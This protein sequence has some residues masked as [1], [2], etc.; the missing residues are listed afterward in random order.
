[1]TCELLDCDGDGVGDG[2]DNCIGVPN[3]GQI[4]S[5][6]DG[7]GDACETARDN[8]S[9]L[10]T[11]TAAFVGADLRG[12]GIQSS[13]VAVDFTDA[14]LSCSYMNG[15][16]FVGGGT[17]VRTNMSRVYISGSN[18][19][20]NNRFEETNVTDM[21]CGGSSIRGCALGLVGSQS[22]CSQ[23]ET[24]EECTDCGN[25]VLDP[26]EECDLGTQNSNT[27][28]TSSCSMTCE[29]MDCDGDTVADGEDN[30]LGVPNADQADTNSDGVGDACET[31]RANCNDLNTGT[32]TF[33]DADL[34]GCRIGSSSVA[35]DFTDADL[36]CS[37]MNGQNFLGDGTFLR[38]NMSG[39]YV[40]GSNFTGNNRFEE[41]NVTDMVCVGSNVQ[42][43]TLDVVGS[44]ACARLDQL[45]V[46]Q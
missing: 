32:A 38:T 6:S 40:S 2:D 20:G 19:T 8:C 11:G 35:V 28:P 16:R 42:G 46:C 12:C 39:V 31:A 5:D 18:V 25:R 29:L 22:M 21:F 30:C 37:Y 17:F 9:D 34:R 3:A 23:L 14:D 15:Q 4:D 33:V 27:Y 1:M 26:S 45:A 10:N 13:S 24:L 36:S 43:C 41:T 44:H 7:S